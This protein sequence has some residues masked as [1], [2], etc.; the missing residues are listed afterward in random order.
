MFSFEVHL[1]VIGEMR[2]DPW[3]EGT[4]KYPII[5]LGLLQAVCL[6][7]DVLFGNGSISMS[8]DQEILV[9]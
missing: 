9:L 8:R 2:S 3:N 1:G 6:F 5:D 4:N 7:A